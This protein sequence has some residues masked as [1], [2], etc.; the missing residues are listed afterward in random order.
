VA[1]QKKRRSLS[2][3][4]EGVAPPSRNTIRETEKEQHNTSLRP[5]TREEAQMVPGK[6]G[7]LVAASTPVNMTFTVSAKERY[8]WT[9]ELRRRGLSAVSV[10]RDAM[11]G[12]L[13]DRTT[14]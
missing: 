11:N 8:E 2:E 12:L 7:K 1:N 9:I 4:F 13:E 14:K 10:L 5:D 3:A 6:G